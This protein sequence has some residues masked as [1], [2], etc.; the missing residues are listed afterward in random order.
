MFTKRLLGIAC[1]VTVVVLGVAGV[2]RL[3]K[4]RQHGPSQSSNTTQAVA[5][6][7]PQP[8]PR[9]GPSQT[10]FHFQLDP[11]PSQGPKPIEPP[12]LPELLPTIEPSAGEPPMIDAPA[13]K[14]PPLPTPPKLSA[15]PKP[16]LP[17]ESTGEL[18]KQLQES[19]ER[20]Q[21]SIAPPIVGSAEESSLP[22]L[23]QTPKE[24]TYTPPA[25]V[26]PLPPP[27]PGL[28]PPPIQPVEAQESPMK[29]SPIPVTPPP[30]PVPAAP[31]RPDST[32]KASG[33]SPP[34][35]PLDL[36]IQHKGIGTDAPAPLPPPVVGSPPENPLRNNSTPP[37]AGASSITPPTNNADFQRRLTEL[38]ANFLR[39]TV[40]EL[41]R[42][43]QALP[44]DH[45]DRR[46]VEVDHQRTSERLARLVRSLER[47]SAVVETNFTQPAESPWQMTMETIDG[48]T[49]L[50]AMVHRRARFKVVCDRLDM[51][52]PR[53]TL[54]AV[55]HVQLSGEGFHGACDALSIPLHEDRLI[56]EGS[57]EL[58]VRTQMHA[59]IEPRGETVPPLVDQRRPDSEPGAVPMLNLRGEHL[60]LRWH[61]L[62]REDSAKVDAPTPGVVRTPAPIRATA[63]P[64]VNVAFAPERNEQWS[65]W[66]TLRRRTGDR[67][68]LAVYTLED[69]Q[70]KTIATIQAP[71]GMSLAE[72]V[73]RR[74][75]VFG[76]AARGERGAVFQASHV[77]WE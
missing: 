56:L 9:P 11:Q 74:V 40:A 2:D 63:G 34:P 23:P 12:P 61:E 25:P 64:M 33:V 66:G 35:V 59:L 77:A 32:D 21:K 58:S 62:V 57:A 71:A 5:A 45:A 39:E 55:G 28:T 70:G 50:Q 6:T 43:L 41:Q 20:L 72:Y 16:A 75:S 14:T 17:L 36:P 29:A 65:E 19:L 1:L 44:R 22:D 18:E 76:R 38:E 54:L 10:S 8:A 51:Q 4:Q 30:L 68:G 48:K 49:V 69:G 60:D 73:G 42:R 24:A 47:R 31:A 15:P 26:P 13:A 53:G 7:N 52:A 46:K 37:P 27:T 3:S 67:D